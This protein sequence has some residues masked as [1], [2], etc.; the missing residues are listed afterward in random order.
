MRISLLAGMMA[1]TAS[2]A[3][4]GS[5]EVI[6]K[7]N[8][9]AR[10]IQK[11]SCPIC[12]PLKKKKAEIQ[13][14]SLAPGTEKVEVRQ[15]D[16]VLKVY[17]TEAWLGGSPVTYVSKASTGLVGPKIAQIDQKSAA[18]ATAELPK[19]TAVTIDTSTTSAVTADM[20]PPD[21]GAKARPEV[22]RHND[23]KVKVEKDAVP[24]ISK[25]VT[26]QA[27]TDKSGSTRPAEKPEIAQHFNPQ[28]IELRLKID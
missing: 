12:A 7:D 16:G 13:E 26:S 21:L 10:S 28:N 8:D 2:A 22:T 25:D 27:T 6:R 4:A 15:V 24:T 5:I 1:V 3:H 23:P 14:I 17:R 20:S 18:P 19:D 9:S 11:V